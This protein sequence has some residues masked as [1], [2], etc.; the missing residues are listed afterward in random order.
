MRFF[1][2]Q[3]HFNSNFKKKFLKSTP[4][5]R[6]DNNFHLFFSFSSLSTSKISIIWRINHIQSLVH[7]TLSTSLSKFNL[8]ASLFSLGSFMKCIYLKNISYERPW[9]PQN[10]FV[11]LTAEKLLLAIS[12]NSNGCVY[13]TW[14]WSF[15]YNSNWATFK[16]TL[17]RSTV[18]PLRSRKYHYM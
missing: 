11:L 16:S 15:F 5:C 9:W 2:F 17:K 6:F 7:P 18:Q 3:K 13:V 12:E 8:Q 10:N 14:S 4:F 1:Y